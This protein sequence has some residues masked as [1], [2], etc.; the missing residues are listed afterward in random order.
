VILVD[1]RSIHTPL[2]R[3]LHSPLS[4]LAELPSSVPESDPARIL[5][6]IP[7]FEEQPQAISTSSV[8]VSNTNSKHILFSVGSIGAQVKAFRMSFETPAACAPHNVPLSLSDT[9]D[10]IDAA[11]ITNILSD[12][13]PTQ[14]LAPLLASRPQVLTSFQQYLKQQNPLINL[15]DALL[16]SKQDCLYLSHV[17]TGFACIPFDKC[18]AVLQLSSSGL[19]LRHDYSFGTLNQSNSDVPDDLYVFEDSVHDES[20][21]STLYR[22]APKQDERFPTRIENASIMHA[23]TSC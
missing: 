6:D 8:P 19:I 14:N 17:L 10:R 15:Q 5:I 18:V 7:S 2:A 4:T 21:I 13:Q 9:D 3:W 12:R 23:C 16:K 11:N 1:Q 20:G 22:P